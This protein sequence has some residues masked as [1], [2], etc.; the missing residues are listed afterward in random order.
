MSEFC[1]FL[2][3]EDTGIWRE[4]GEQ[5]FF[6]VPRGYYGYVDCN[7]YLDVR[8]PGAFKGILC[9]PFISGVGGRKVIPSRVEL[10]SARNSPAPSAT[11]CSARVHFDLN[12]AVAWYSSPVSHTF[13]TE[14]CSRDGCTSAGSTQQSPRIPKGG[15]SQLPILEDGKGCNAE[16]DVSKAAAT[17]SQVCG[18][19][20]RANSANRRSPSLVSTI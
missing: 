19:F 3:S 11:V 7:W 13:Y 18:A 15:K 1:F 12:C 8:L 14:H 4:E 17:L 20:S 16:V 2:I 5:Q 10:C 6:V 9:L